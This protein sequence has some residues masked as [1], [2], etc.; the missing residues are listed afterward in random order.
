MKSLTDDPGRAEIFACGPEPMLKTLAEK[1]RSWGYPMQLSLEERMACGIGACQ[2]CA[3][4]VRRE[5][6]TGYL[7]VCRD[8]PVFNSQE[9]VW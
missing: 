1:N 2:G 7:R 9:V 5:N 4:Q 6:K 8:G 3:V